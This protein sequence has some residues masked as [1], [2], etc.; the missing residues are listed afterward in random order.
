MTRRTIFARLAA[1]GLI[2]SSVAA[3]LAQSD[4]ATATLEMNPTMLDFAGDRK[5]GEMYMP[6]SSTLSATKPASVRKEPAYASTPL[7]GVITVGTGPRSAHAFAIDAPSGADAKIYIDLD[8]NGDL[9]NSKAGAWTDKT[10]SDGIAEY[11]GTYLFRVSYGTPTKETS[12]GTFGLNLYWSQGRSAVNYYRAGVRYGKIKVGGQE[13]SVKII[14]QNNEAVYNLPFAV[15]GHPTK[16]IWILLDE[17]RFDARGTFSFGGMNYQAVLSPDGSKLTM[18]ATARSVTPPVVN[19][20]AKE[21]DLLAVGTTAPDFEVP[22]WDGGTVSLASLRGK[23]VVLDFWA[24]W[25]GPCKA[26]LPHVQ[27]IHDMVKDKNV[28]VLAMNVFDD[29][30]AYDQWVPS[31]KQYTFHFAYDPAGR[32]NSSIAKSKYMVSGIPT[33]YVID[34]NGKIAASILGFGGLDDHRLEQ[35]LAKLGVQTSEPSPS[36]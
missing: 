18:F 31:N 26:S 11:H 6:S 5:A 27:K 34:Q 25:C 22:A 29:K 20:A 36:K 4:K 16:P 30:A 17:T 14:D 8:G 35:A 15:N 32:D 24:T 1:T 13:Y 33:T 3:A 12:H 23:I 10:V 28:Y 21:P 9:T 2:L 19:N 7:Y